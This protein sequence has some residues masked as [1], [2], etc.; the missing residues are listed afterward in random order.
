MAAQVG[1]EVGKNNLRP[2]IPDNCPSVYANLIKRCWQ[3]D[4]SLRPGFKEILRDLRSMRSKL[5]KL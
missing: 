1:I 2:V 3:R 4:P 5:S